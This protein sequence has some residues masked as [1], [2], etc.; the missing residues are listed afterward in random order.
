[1]SLTVFAL[2]II[3]NLRFKGIG[4]LAHEVFGAPF[5]LWLAPVN[6]A[7]RII[8]EVAKPIS[9]R[10]VFSATCSRA[11]CCSSSWCCS[12]GWSGE[13]VVSTGV[14]VLAHVLLSLGWAVFHILVITLQAFIFM[15]L[16]IVYL[17]DGARASLIVCSVSS[18]F[19]QEELKWKTLHTSRA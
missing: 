14:S 16:T 4:G 18:V 12:P 10:G 17:V 2:I 7:L 6:F 8:E 9:L 11:R 1:M 15:V 19:L 3:F 5:G 13:A